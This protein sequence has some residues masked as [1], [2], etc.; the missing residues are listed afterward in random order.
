MK[1]LARMRSTISLLALLT[2]VDLIFILG[3]FRVVN[4]AEF[5]CSS[6]N[7]TC[8][9]AAINEANTHAG[10]DTINLDPSTYTL[11]NTFE[12]S[13][14]PS[15]TSDITINGEDAATTIIERCSHG[16]PYFRCCG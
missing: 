15:V 3:A 11:T 6:G 2:T 10:A 5:F 8:L 16:I 1:I 4:G 9:I 12:F 14:L 13:V 7:V